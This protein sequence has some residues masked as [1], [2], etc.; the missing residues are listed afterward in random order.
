[1]NSRRLSY[2][3]PSMKLIKL[4]LPILAITI[5]APTWAKW[6]LIERESE[7]VLAR[8]NKLK[9]IAKNISKTTLPTE[10]RNKK[11][12]L[13][14]QEGRISARDFSSELTQFNY[15]KREMIDCI[16]V[17]RDDE[18]RPEFCQE[19]ILQE[20]VL[21]LRSQKEIDDTA[22]L[23][24]LAH[25]KQNKKQLNW[26]ASRALDIPSY[27]R[28]LE[29]LSKSLER[30]GV[31]PESTFFASR[32]QRRNVKP[33]GRITP[34]QELFLKY[35]LFE[36]KVLNEILERTQKRIAAAKISIIVD[37][38]GNGEADETIAVSPSERYRFAQNMLK[39]ELVKETSPDG[40]LP[41]ASVEGPHMIMASSELGFIDEAILKQLANMPELKS[42][43]AQKGKIYLNALWSIG[44]AGLLAIPG[45]IYL[46][47]PI[48]II[49]SYFQGK[50]AQEAKNAPTL[51]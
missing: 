13:D 24:L 35:N 16:E 43:K 32:K 50:K 31:K 18:Y 30:K 15:F 5:S 17:S 20:I 21:Y 2:I 10:L 14:L 9:R 4:L 23:I 34:R 12:I 27:L 41:R 28:T 3:W 22:G 1:M 40:F 25:I 51:F 29:G 38:D 44:K 11:F 26:L 7:S 47:L 48:V 19:A 36:I 33:W 37:Y 6:P 8:E 39:L 45:G 42:K 46:A 49:E